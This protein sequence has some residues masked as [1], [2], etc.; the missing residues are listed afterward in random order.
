MNG[1]KSGEPTVLRT[2]EKNVCTLTLNRPRARN[3]LTL[4][5]I[6]S[7][8]SELQ[9]LKTDTSIRVVILAGAGP[10]FCSGHDL[11]QLKDYNDPEWTLTLFERCA[12]MMLTLT[13]IPQPVIARVHGTATAA[14]CQLVATC[15]LAIAS[16]DAKFA[17]PG[18]NIGLFCSTP[19]VALSRNIGRKRAMQMLL[20]GE[21]ITAKDAETAGLIN[22]AVPSGMLDETVDKLV[23]SI[24]SKSPRILEIGKNAFYEQI[25]KNIAEAYAYTAA[26]M[27]RNMM[28][29]DCVEGIDAFIAKRPP[30]WAKLRE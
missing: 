15:D 25:D 29:D 11:K 2:D 8:T 5:M 12:E 6:D 18:V 1:K 16:D 9:A 3:A 27:A 10:V 7:V 19:M 24:C 4:K 22:T 17:T 28:E 21:P 13:Q 30:E 20:T 26:V 23:G 14:G